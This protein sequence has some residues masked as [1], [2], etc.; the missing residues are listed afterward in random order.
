MKN[1]IRMIKFENDIDFL[2]K[3]IGCARNGQSGISNSKRK[4]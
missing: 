2:V 3:K 4:S 1:L